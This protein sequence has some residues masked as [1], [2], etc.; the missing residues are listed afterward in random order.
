MIR[1]IEE[2]LGYLNEKRGFDFSGNRPAMIELCIDKRL[3][4][5][6]IESIEGYFDYLQFYHQELDNLVDA[7][8][9]NV[10]SFF[11]DPLTFGYL[12]AIIIPRLILEKTKSG[13]KMLRVWSAGCAAGEEPYSIAMEISEFLKEDKDSF[14]LNIFGT[15]IDV[16]TLKR[17]R[18][19]AYLPQ[20]LENLKYGYLKYFTKKEELFYLGQEIKKLVDFS[21]YDLLEKKSFAPPESVYGSFDIVL[22]RNVLIYY[23]DQHQDKIFSKLFRSL[24]KNGYLVLGESEIPVGKYQ[25]YFKKVNDCC[26]IFKKIS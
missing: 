10:S 22:C 25:P 15:D 14:D 4:K 21:Q 19:A 5:T 26:H 1:E 7:L 9:I 11:R 8:R 17:A 16:R 6:G 18:V 20:S 12:A 2:I 13:N 3:S 23:N 24:E